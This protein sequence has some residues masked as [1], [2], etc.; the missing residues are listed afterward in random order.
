MKVEP[1]GD[2]SSLP[3]VDLPGN[4]SSFAVFATVRMAVL[5]CWMKEACEIYLQS[6]GSS[7]ANCVT[8]ESDSEDEDIEADKE[9]SP[10]RIPKV[11]RI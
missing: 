3:E 2:V 1:I 11:G 10:P 7:P 8:A 9:H 4:A 5:E 6:S